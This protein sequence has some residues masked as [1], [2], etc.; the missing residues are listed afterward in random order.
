MIKNSL[1]LELN[2]LYPEHINEFVWEKLGLYQSFV[3]PGNSLKPDSLYLETTVLNLSIS[4]TYRR[5]TYIYKPL[6]HD[7]TH[8]RRVSRH[9]SF[10]EVNHFIGL[11]GSKRHS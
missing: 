9:Y 3:K 8:S 2:S 4:C 10:I 6:L 11:I 7:P 5:V 1:K